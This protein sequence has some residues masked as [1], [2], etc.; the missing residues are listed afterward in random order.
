L[1]PLPNNNLKLP[2]SPIKLNDSLVN[3]KKAKGDTHTINS[4]S[5]YESMTIF[6]AK[7]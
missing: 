3:I 5:D 6:S 4:L 1:S 2:D 7:K